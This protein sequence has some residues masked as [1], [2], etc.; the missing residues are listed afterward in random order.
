ML[1][2]LLT[3]FVRAI[4]IL[5]G[6]TLITFL[7]MHAI[8]GNPWSNYSSNPRMM[9]N[10]GGDEFLRRELAHRFGLDLP[11]WRQF[12]RYTI[13]DV[14]EDGRFFCGA[15]C[16]NLG[17]SIQQRGRT[18]VEVLFAPPE[19]KTFRESRF[20]YSIRLVLFASLIATGLGI[21]LGILSA[22]KPTSMFG[23]TIS[24]GLAALVSIPNFVLGLLAIIVLASWLKLITVLPHWD[25]PSD[26]IVPAVVLAAIPMASIARVTSASM[27]NILNEDYVRTA[28]GKGLAERRVILVHTMRNA[29]VPI[30]TFLGP[31][32][33]ELF[34]G[35]LIVENLYAFPGFGREYWQAVVE[36]DYPMIMGLTLIF[37]IGILFVNVVVEVVCEILDPRLRSIKRE[38]A[39]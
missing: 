25:K 21:P 28:R 24:V 19:G 38:G 30:I 16:G 14:D 35:L 31:T 8:P 5:L 1:R 2:F 39:P 34:T 26:W 23:R 7:L 12:I 20:G 3:R 11:L 32:L 6:V 36:L 4:I 33:M 9:L 10:L 17:P 13:G 27:M 18:V 37:A 15:V 29:L 22:I